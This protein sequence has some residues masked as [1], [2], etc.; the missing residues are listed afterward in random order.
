M[1]SHEWRGDRQ[2]GLEAFSHP[3]DT[4]GSSFTQEVVGGWC[5]FGA[6]DQRAA[7]VANAGARDLGAKLAIGVLLKGGRAIL[8][9]P[10]TLRANALRCAGGSIC[11]G[12]YR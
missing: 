11:L 9:S 2:L 12:S 4:S 8:A 6:L 5:S 1:G 7:V 3:V 10:E